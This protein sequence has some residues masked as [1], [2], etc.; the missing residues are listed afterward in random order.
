LSS[1]R[2]GIAIIGAGYWGRK[3]VGEYLSL[4]KKRN[5]A[6]LRYVVDSD[7]KRLASVANDFGLPANILETDYLR[8]LKN[9]S[10]DAVHLATPN[11]THFPIGMAV[12]E[13]HKSLLMEKPMATNMREALKLARMAEMNGLILHVDH[14]FRFNNAVREAREILAKGLVGKPLHF[15]IRWESLRTPPPGADIILDLGPH[16]VDVL[17]YLCNEWPSR[18][19]ALGKSFLRKKQGHEEVAEAVAEFEDDVLARISLSWLYA[20][21]RMRSISVTGELGT[22][23]L[24][25]LNQQLRTYRDGIEENHHVQANNT[26]E[27]VIAHFLDNMTKGEPPQNS[28]LIGAMTVAVLSAMRESM[29]TGSFVNVLGG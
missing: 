11:A 23:E 3:L 9:D 27:S 18:V 2:L 22:M 10:I 13:S 19:L 14:I 21:P 17:N 28:A 25:A 6:E 8:I 24:D 26:I 4:T 5:D 12:L 29:K 20:G 16:P 7:K 15:G 1:R